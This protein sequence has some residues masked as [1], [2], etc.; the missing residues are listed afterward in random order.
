M[1]PF[2]NLVPFIGVVQASD[3]LSLT[4]RCKV[5][6]FGYHP[7]ASDPAVPV[8][9]LP[10]A[11]VL[12][13]S[14][15]GVQSPEPK[16]GEWVFGF[17][18]DGRDAQF[19]M[20]IGSIPGHSL[21]NLNNCWADGT[22]ATIHNAVKLAAGSH[23]TGVDVE[24][25][26]VVG[27]AAAL[28]TEVIA[29]DGNGIWVPSIQHTGTGAT[30]IN[31]A[32]QDGA[33]VIASDGHCT[34]QY[35]GSV[36]Q[37]QSDG[38]VVINS[39]GNIF[40]RA[41]G[42]TTEASASTKNI[43]IENGNYN[44]RVQGNCNLDVAGSFS[45]VVDG[46]YS[47]YATGLYSVHAQGI[48]MSAAKMGLTS[49]ETFN[50]AAST[51]MNLACKNISLSTSHDGAVGPQEAPR[52]SGEILI[53]G[54]NSVYMEIAQN[55][56]LTV[57]GETRLKSEGNI[58]VQTGKDFNLLANSGKA[59]IGADEIYLKSGSSLV[60]I[61]SNQ[62]GLNTSNIIAL[63]A[64]TLIDMQNGSS[65]A[66]GDVEIVAVIPE[67]PVLIQQPTVLDVEE[68]PTPNTGATLGASGIS[69]G[70]SGVENIDAGHDGDTSTGSF[71]GGFNDQGFDALGNF[72]FGGGA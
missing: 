23:H 2:S 48:E 47:V 57:G 8:E 70:G 58:D 69:S 22:P 1:I 51:E 71:D 43:V 15:G 10:W 17:F 30:S 39:T 28:P 41:A 62:I 11:I 36:V 32:S 25:S 55:V 9:V 13:S 67:K 61:L 35:R 52:P 18:L 3:D 21:G 54:E 37:I 72:N 6:C 68:K 12:N 5:R 65:I 27:A 56:N 16:P 66:P 20:I 33:H 46:N 60:S 38:S 42:V 50:V 31:S 7:P 26:P 14:L 63:D 34:M 59:Q 45:A 40:T 64:K 44:I 49:S 24:A 53:K 4:G 19:P 29:A